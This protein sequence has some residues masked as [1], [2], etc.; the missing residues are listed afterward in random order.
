MKRM[1]APMI[2][3]LVSSLILTLVVIP[4]VYALVKEWR[5]RRGR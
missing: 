3:G 5:I 2:G 1:A 4:V